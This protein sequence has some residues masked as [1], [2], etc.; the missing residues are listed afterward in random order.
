[1]DEQKRKKI[2]II[3]SFLFHIFIFLFISITGLLKFTT[4]PQYDEIVEI[5]SVSGSV[6]AVHQRISQTLLIHHL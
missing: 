6:E 1:M 2:S 3:G 4:L 5:T